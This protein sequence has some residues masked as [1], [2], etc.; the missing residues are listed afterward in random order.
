MTSADWQESDRL[1]AGV[2]TAFGSRTGVVP[3]GGY[4]TFDGVMVNNVRRPRIEGA[5]AGERMRAFDVV[6]GRITGRAVI[7]NSY[8]DVTNGVITDGDS[9]MQADGRFS[10]GFPRRDAGEEINARIRVI[11]RPLRD[12]RHAFDL[13]DYNVDGLFSGEFH[14]FGS[15]LDAVRLRP[16]GD[17][18]GRRVRAAV[19]DRDGRRASRRRGRAP[20]FAA[21]RAGRR[22][23]ARRGVGR[24][25]RHLLVQPRWPRHSARAASRC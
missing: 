15:Y 6:W 21:D 23:R 12:L 17:R 1:F 13:D 16:D 25:E 2:L 22:P 4:G 8:V 14:V 9:V 24:A 7:E 5:F 11:N 19:R 20:R 10:L 18:A 3:L